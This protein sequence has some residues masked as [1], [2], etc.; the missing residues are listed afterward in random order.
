MLSIREIAAVTWT[1]F[2]FLLTASSKNLLK[3]RP[4]QAEN[5]LVSEYLV[6]TPARN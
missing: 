3:E 5:T 1:I 4:C 6:A 2:Q